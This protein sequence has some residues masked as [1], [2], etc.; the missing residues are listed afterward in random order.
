[1]KNF[2]DLELKTNEIEL[3]KIE[4]QIKILKNENEHKLKILIAKGNSQIANVNLEGDKLTQK[5]NQEK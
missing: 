1:M 3:S 2:I 5:F 4:N